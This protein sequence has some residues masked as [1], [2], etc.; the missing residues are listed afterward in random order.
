MH[1][2]RDID[3]DGVTFYDHEYPIK[4]SSY[5]QGLR[6]YLKILHKQRPDDPLNQRQEFYS[7]YTSEDKDG[8]QLIFHDPFEI[9]SDHSI[10]FYTQKDHEKTFK[11]TPEFVTY[12]ETFADYSLE[13][14]GCYLNEERKLKYFQVHNQ[15]NCLEECLSDFMSLECGCVKFYMIRNQSTR[16]CGLTDSK[17]FENA[18]EIFRTNEKDCNCVGSCEILKYQIELHSMKKKM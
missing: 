14:R 1:N 2:E 10:S 16:I 6:G 3:G 11:I 15:V 4:A 7:H 5:D 8:Y 18:E 12:D 9:P 13:E 17:C